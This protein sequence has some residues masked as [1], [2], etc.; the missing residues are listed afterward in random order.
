MIKIKEQIA[1]DRAERSDKFNKE[2]LEREEKRKVE[3]EESIA[4][5]KAE[6]EA[7]KKAEE[8]AVAKKKAEL[9]AAVKKKAEEEAKNIP[10]KQAHPGRL[11]ANGQTNI[12]NSI[13]MLIR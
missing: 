4:K 11:D 6:L 5:K 13:K 8:I 3:M 12:Q 1:Q 10:L 7:K 2:K 9:E